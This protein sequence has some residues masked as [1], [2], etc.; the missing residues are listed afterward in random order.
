MDQ[1]SILL[2]FDYLCLISGELNYVGEGLCTSTSLWTGISL[3]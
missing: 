1:F 2:T 3:R